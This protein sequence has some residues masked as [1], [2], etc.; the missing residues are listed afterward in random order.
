VLDGGTR[1]IDAPDFHRLLA[2]MGIDAPM[3][4]N[5]ADIAKNDWR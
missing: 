1:M 3:P 5:L 2:V 4:D